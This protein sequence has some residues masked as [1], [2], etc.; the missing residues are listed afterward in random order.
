MC[1]PG[2]WLAF[3][4]AFL[5]GVKDIALWVSFCSESLR[6]LAAS[7]MSLFHWFFPWSSLIPLATTWA[8]VWLP[9]WW[10]APS[11]MAGGTESRRSGKHLPHGSQSQATRGWMCVQLPF[12]P[13]VLSP[14]FTRQPHVA[15]I[16]HPC[17]LLTPMGRNWTPASALNGRRWPG[18]NTQQIVLRIFTSHNSHYYLRTFS[19]KYLMC[20][21]HTPAI[22]PSFPYHWPSLCSLRQFHFCFHVTC[23]YVI[24]FIYK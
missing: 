21:E 9:S 3:V 6:E 14:T 4:P 8:V 20:A 10:M 19:Y 7:W 11:A 1:E 12:G 2:K 16:S 13:T 5:L 18:E 22:R 17:P 15:I 24:L 23:P